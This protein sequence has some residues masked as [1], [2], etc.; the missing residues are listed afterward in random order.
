[1]VGTNY[2][3]SKKS[4]GR[5]RGSTT[6]SKSKSKSRTQQ[7]SDSPTNLGATMNVEAT[8]TPPVN[9]NEQEP[10]DNNNLNGEKKADDTDSKP[11][12]D[13]ATNEGDD[14]KSTNGSKEAAPEED[15]PKEDAAASGSDKEED[16]DEETEFNDSKDD[17]EGGPRKSTKSDGQKADVAS[18][19]D[20]STD[21]KEEQDNAPTKPTKTRNGGN[22]PHVPRKKDGLAHGKDTP[23]AVKSMLSQ[24]EVSRKMANIIKLPNGAKLTGKAKD[25]AHLDEIKMCVA[26]SQVFAR[27]LFEPTTPQSNGR[28]TCLIT[29]GIS[30]DD[31]EIIVECSNAAW[32]SSL[33]DNLADVST[34][35]GQR[36]LVKQAFER[37]MSKSFTNTV[38]RDLQTDTKS[39][40]GEYAVMY[41]GVIFVMRAIE[42]ILGTVTERLAKLL[43]IFRKNARFKGKVISAQE[44]GPY[45]EALTEIQAQIDQVDPQETSIMHI[46]YVLNVLR[47]KVTDQPP[48]TVA[49]A[50]YSKKWHKGKKQDTAMETLEHVQKL[51]DELAD[52][53]DDD[54]SGDDSSQIALMA[55]AAEAL[56]DK[57][58]EIAKLQAQ[59]AQAKRTVQANKASLQQ[60]QQN[61][62]PPTGG[63]RYTP[64]PFLTDKPSD[65]T[66]VK[67]HGGKD[68]KWCDKCAKWVCTHDTATHK[69]DFKSK[70]G[71]SGTKRNNNN[72][73]NNSNKKSK[74]AA[75]LAAAAGKK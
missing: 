1:M 42:L 13:A 7:D 27:L 59:L 63:N 69:A 56:E 29:D 17:I 66:Q 34:E 36:Y 52:I 71:N 14:E 31:R 18:D 55:E 68:W 6:K 21:E 49:L 43:E 44:V 51:W 2:H 65:L 72:N 48:F 57:D 40:Y 4:G 30:A 23:G 10:E 60:N 41:D 50:D 8:V 26:S 11:A 73:N 74:L 61:Q 16:S 33:I 5:K 35:Q 39:K 45:L 70:K 24:M 37:V 20:E 38:Q 75:K 58:S 64:P 47:K 3:R 22:S 46:S 53:S 32:D 12:A 54:D 28:E 62:Q 25:A 15:H 19:D 67:Q 9:N